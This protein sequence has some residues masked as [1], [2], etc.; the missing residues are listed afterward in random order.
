MTCFRHPDVPMPG[1]RT[2]RPLAALISPVFA[3]I[4]G[5]YADHATAADPVNPVDFDPTFLQSG[6]K[7]DVSRFSRGNAI[8]PGSYYVDVWLNDARTAR[9]NVRFVPTGEGQS[10]RACVT[11]LMLEKWGVDFS[12]VAATEGNATPPAANE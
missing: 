9:E 7:V 5:L 4:A 12:R 3:M 8:A 1:P 10:A 2:L 11:R 6:S